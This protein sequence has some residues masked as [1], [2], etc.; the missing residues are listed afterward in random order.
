MWSFRWTNLNPLHPRM[1]CA[2]FGWNW[3][4]GSGEDF[5]CHQCVFSISLLSPLRNLE[6]QLLMD[7]LCQVW[8]ELAQWLLRR[9]V[10]F[11]YVFSLFCNHLP[12]E[13]RAWLC[14]SSFVQNWI[15]F[16]QGCFLS[17]LVEI[18]PVV[19][20]KKMK[21]CKSLQTDRDR[22]MDSR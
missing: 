15:T 6:S 2:K 22:Q 14:I 13:K 7:A 21:M 8:F 17:S 11:G 19:L 9:S 4:N 20:Q 5:K 12:S 3:P 16:T 10:N 18:S 1:L